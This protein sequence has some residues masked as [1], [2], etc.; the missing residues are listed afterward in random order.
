MNSMNYAHKLFRSFARWQ[1]QIVNSEIELSSL[2]RFHF[3]TLYSI[4]LPSNYT[5]ILQLSSLPLY[6]WS[7]PYLC[8]KLPVNP[9]SIPWGAAPRFLW[10]TGSDVFR[11]KSVPSSPMVKRAFSRLG[12]ITAGWGRSIRK[13]GST[14]QSEDRKRWASSQDCSSTCLNPYEEQDQF[15]SYQI[16]FKFIQVWCI[17]KLVNIS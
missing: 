2:S 13:H 1:V 3:V 5:Q 16:F 10:D 17:I 9:I 11:P 14:L 7:H 15:I 4:F 6:T 12:T 8:I